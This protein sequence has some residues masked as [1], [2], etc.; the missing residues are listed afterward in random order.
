M[1]TIEIENQ[2]VRLIR[3]LTTSDENKT[4]PVFNYRADT[5]LSD[6]NHLSELK[7]RT[8]KLFSPP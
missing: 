2:I 4:R 1:T 8:I 5:N 7:I 3:G 6:L